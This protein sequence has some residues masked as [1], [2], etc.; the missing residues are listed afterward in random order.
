[1]KT[2][3]RRK[4]LIPL[5][6]VLLSLPIIN[7]HAEVN[8]QNNADSD[9]LIK[10]HDLTDRILDALEKLVDFYEKNYEAM[11]LDGI[12]GLRALEG[13]LLN[14]IGGKVPEGGRILQDGPV[15]KR[16]RA[17]L[18]STTEI[19]AKAL[20]YLQE[21]APDYLKLMK[22]IMERPFRDSS[23]TLRIRQIDQNLIWTQQNSES[24]FNHKQ[25]ERSDYCISSLIGTRGKTG[26]DEESRGEDVA[27]DGQDGGEGEDGRRAKRR[28][29]R[30]RD[31][32]RER[33]GVGGREQTEK[34]RRE[35]R[36]M[37][38][39]GR[40]RDKTGQKCAIPET[41]VSFKLRRGTS[42]YIT[43]HQLLYMH[44][45]LVDGCVDALANAL[46]KSGVKKRQ[47]ENNRN[48]D[49]VKDDDNN[50]LN[51]KL[52][53][54]WISELCTNIAVQ[55]NE[56][57]KVEIDG[58]LTV[59]TGDQDLL[60][61]QQFVCAFL[62][63]VDVL[64]LPYL[65]LALS[66][67]KENGCFGEDKLKTSRRNLLFESDV[68]S[69]GCLSHKTAVGSGALAVYLYFSIVSPSSIR[70]HPTLNLSPPKTDL[71]GHQQLQQ[72]QQLQRRIRQRQ[73]QQQPP[74]H[75]R[76]H[77]ARI[78]KPLEARQIPPL[79]QEANL[80][81]PLVIILLFLFVSI[82]TVR[83]RFNIYR[84]MWSKCV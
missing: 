2:T 27:P 5:L 42:G 61:E 52:V 15:K 7:C 23:A 18:D 77:A 4:S 54:E 64:S 83:M 58:S 48:D 65:S 16:V 70:T 68:G 17:L 28:R 31:V 74:R 3:L 35:K 66:W 62:G 25:E 9:A 63:F 30:R 44:L 24:D 26:N 67:Q 56:S 55:A 43:T 71:M 76:S 60:L 21:S 47:T 75:I 78:R 36:E 6:I 46:D 57:V 73:Q 69:S 51:M 80:V 45:G 84:K 41:C 32:S 29:R 40:F 59:N 81:L 1:M 53:D 10:E 39:E 33:K 79:S 50:N 19:A 11:N 49:E 34:R 22:P 13:Q 20:P 8:T 37:M 72:L 14:L 38:R 82:M 12:F